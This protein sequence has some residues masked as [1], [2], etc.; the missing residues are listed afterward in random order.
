MKQ[1]IVGYHRDEHQD[2]VAELSCG[3][4]RHVRHRP[5]FF[6][7]PWVESQSGRDS[8]LGVA[9]ECRKCDDGAPLDVSME[10]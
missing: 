2:W 5:P 3:H 8:M 7:R 1:P 6:N 9:L 4:F 10:T